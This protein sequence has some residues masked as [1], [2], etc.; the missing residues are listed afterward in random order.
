MGG[1][2]GTCDQGET[3]LLLSLLQ[4]ECTWTGLSALPS[5]DSEGF[6]GDGE[7]RFPLGGLSDTPVSLGGDKADRK[8]NLDIVMT[9]A[10]VR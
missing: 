9:V 5:P 4:K 10:F 2:G 1:G 7:G 6:V 3:Q 8:K